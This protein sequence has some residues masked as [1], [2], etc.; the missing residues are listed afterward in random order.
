M[1]EAFHSVAHTE[2]SNTLSEVFDLSWLLGVL[3]LLSSRGEARKM[4][5]RK[6]KKKKICLFPSVSACFCICWD[7]SSSSAHPKCWGFCLCHPMPHSCWVLRR[8]TQP[9][10]FS[11]ARVISE[12]IRKGLQMRIFGV[13]SNEIFKPCSLWDIH[14]HRFTYPL[15]TDSSDWQGRW[16]LTCINPASHHKPSLQ[17]RNPS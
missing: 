6:K 16:Q 2:R 1:A 7:W 12:D 13:W 5:K 11:R 8:P 3:T 15:L 4:M 17:S 14:H 9:L 10:L